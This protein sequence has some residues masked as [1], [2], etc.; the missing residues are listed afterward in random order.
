MT[1]KITIL[2]AVATMIL[3]GNVALASIE[4]F[5]DY[6]VGTY[7]QIGTGNWATTTEPMEV[8]NEQ[9]KS[10]LNS[11]RFNYTNLEKRGI[12]YYTETN[13]TGFDVYIEDGGCGSGAWNTTFYDGDGSIITEFTTNGIN[14]TGGCYITGLY[15]SGARFDIGT[16]A[17][18]TWHTFITQKS[19]Q[20]VRWS[21]NDGYTF[22]DWQNA[23]TL[24][25]DGF[26]RTS[27]YTN[28]GANGFMD[29]I[30]TEGDFIEAEFNDDYDTSKSYVERVTLAWKEST[31]T[32]SDIGIRVNG[33]V[34]KSESYDS[35][36]MFLY[37]DDDTFIA[38]ST[39]IIDPHNTVEEPM[40]VGLLY[41][42]GDFSFT[43]TNFEFVKE[44]LEI[45][46][47][48]LKVVIDFYETGVGSQG[49]PQTFRL[50]VDTGMANWTQE[51]FEET[52]G[53][54][55]LGN[56]LITGLGLEEKLLALKDDFLSKFPISWIFQLYE[57]WNTKTTELDY[58]GTEDPLKLE[59][60]MPTTGTG[61]LEETTLTLV[62]ME[63][64][65]EDYGGIV[66]TFRT[67]F[68]YILWIGGML[69]IIGKSRSFINSLTKD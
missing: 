26:E 42:L 31:A 53:E 1:K 28:A 54:I 13:Q 32:S 33:K 14:P 3:T 4:T 15:E 51:S 57:I 56:S 36:T 65:V 10:G 11:A 18:S 7:L 16:I 63:S 66:N 20:T 21:V 48:Y 55:S 22:S 23:Y 29:N 62:D 46:D 38:S 6:S 59:I 25:E 40:A 49:T 68:E 39:E 2:I 5:E 27:I 64:V 44:Y 37:E 60:T 9:A 17:T 58:L 24:D 52:Q 19:G 30:F 34:K 69:L 61:L 45:P 43:S 35:I 8:R 67:I 50:R 41:A 12:T 47:T